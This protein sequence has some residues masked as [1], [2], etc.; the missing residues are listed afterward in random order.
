MNT[1]AQAAFP[2]TRF[3]RARQS[4][5][6]RALIREN[7]VSVEDLIGLCSFAMAK[8]LSNPSLQCQVF[9]VA[10]WTNWLKPQKRPQI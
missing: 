6:T 5:Q 10:V 9:F 4:A 7:R 3:R 8:G 1:N 2:K